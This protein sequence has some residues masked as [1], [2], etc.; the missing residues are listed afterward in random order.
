MA[1]SSGKKLHLFDSFEGMARVD[2]TEDRH[3]VGDFS[4][5]SLEHVQQF[6]CGRKGDDPQS[7]VKF[8][9]GWI[10]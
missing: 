5:T 1:A 10:P 9:K 2:T 7:I 6:V 3:E 4:D 8:H